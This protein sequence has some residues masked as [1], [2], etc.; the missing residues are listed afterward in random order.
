MMSIMLF[1][2]TVE[3]AVRKE[4]Q[5]SSESGTA[6]VT[7]ASSGIGSVYADRLASRG[8][9]L[10]LAA[11]RVDRLE[12]RAAELRRRYGIRVEIAGVDLGKGEDLE[13]FARRLREDEKVTLLVNNAG[14]ANMSSLVQLTP[15]KAQ[16]EINVNVTAVVQL[17]LAVLPRFA[18]KSAGTLIN[19]SSVLSIFALPISTTYSSTKAFVTLFTQ[20]LQQEFKD[21]GIRIQA[22]LPATTATDIWDKLGGVSKLDPATVMSAEACVDAALAGLDA[23]ELVTLT[24]LEQDGLWN[25]LERARMAIRAV[26]NTGTPAT[27]YG[28]RT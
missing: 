28:L 7:G 1:P 26:V 13:R 27:R 8:Y 22:V 16:E 11:R 10:L 18:A 25:D 2:S 9:D 6:V 19:I 12:Q 15:A 14:L 23:G 5:M 17:S 3:T 4:R 21:T 24:S 20:G